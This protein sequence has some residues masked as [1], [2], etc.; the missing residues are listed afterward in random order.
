MQP[1][2]GFRDF[3]PDS[4]A[5]RNYIFAKWREVARRYGF[6]EWDGP[7]LELTELYKKKSGDEIVHQLFR[8]ED[9]SHRDV[10]M[11]P[12]L[13]PT[14]ARVVASHHHDF[15][16]PLKWFSIGQF[17][18]YEKRQRG[19]LREHFQLNCDIVG[20]KSVA[21]DVELLALCIDILREFGFSAS[22]IIVRVS[23]RHAWMEFLSARELDVSRATEFLDIVDKLDRTEISIAEA[24][25][26]SFG[27]T[28]QDIT[29]FAQFPYMES[30]QFA[31]FLHE[32][33][34]RRLEDFVLIDPMI[35]RGLAYYTGFVFEVFDKQRE[36]RAI[37]GG[38][39]YDG[40]ISQLS[41]GKLNLPAVGFAMGD[42]VLRDL[43]STRPS[44]KRRLSAAVCRSRK[45]DAYVV[46]A[47]ESKRPEAINFVQKLRRQKWRVEFSL[48]PTRVSR[49][50][51][52]S[53]HV[54]A[55]YA[56]VIG[57]EW[58]LI[59]VKDLHRGGQIQLSSNEP[60][61]QLRKKLTSWRRNRN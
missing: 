20:E 26:A 54:L 41:D 53:Q 19:R 31:E 59:T 13:T 61:S 55:Q 50:F 9:K 17:F 10:S 56:I 44:T 24:K 36:F 6:I 33:R 21:A 29:G 40:L 46:I 52:R 34:T 28:L 14:L 43:M 18:R 42:V 16:K 27:L 2:P 51:E 8:F 49:Q 32:M 47:E 3:L 22:D 30:I 5:A 1:L 58:P 60:V 7:I 48:E 39:R 11:R 15:K 57:A 4:C 23:N 37:A 38:G 12:E 25:L 35:V 45:M